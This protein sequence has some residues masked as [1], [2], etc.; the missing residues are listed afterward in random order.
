MGVCRCESTAWNTRSAGKAIAV[1]E[2]S[3]RPKDTTATTRR[4][5]ASDGSNMCQDERAMR[6]K[7]DPFRQEQGETWVHVQPS[8]AVLQANRAKR[9]RD[10]PQ[11]CGWPCHQ[12]GMKASANTFASAVSR[13]AR[14]E[15]EEKSRG[16]EGG[17]KRGEKASW[18]VSG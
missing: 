5:R 15:G 17:E 13:R 18:R 7:S 1:G 11:A 3:S 14:R 2:I 4:P 6:M 16:E 10:Q 8:T 12:S 9:G